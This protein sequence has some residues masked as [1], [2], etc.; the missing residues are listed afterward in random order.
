MAKELSIRTYLPPTA[1]T[2][3]AEKT[4]ILEGR[5]YTFTFKYNGRRGVW[6][7]DLDDEDGGVVLRGVTVSSNGNLLLGANPDT[8]PPGAIFFEGEPTLE[9]FSKGLFAYGEVIDV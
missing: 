6:E 5:P 9:G 2:P 4:Y 3:Y 1:D 8:A 7:F